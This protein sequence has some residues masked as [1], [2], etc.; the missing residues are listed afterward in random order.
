MVKA[1]GERKEASCKK[2]WKLE[3]KFQ[4]KVIWKLIKKRQRLNIS[5]EKRGKGTVWK[6]DELGCEW[7]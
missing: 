2:C 6:D 5:E 4:K 3:M 7:K 1:A